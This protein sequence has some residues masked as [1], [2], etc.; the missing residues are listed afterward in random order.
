MTEL[1]C[2]FC[3][4]PDNRLF[5]RG[6]LVLGLWDQ[7]PV[8]P[9]HALVIPRRHVASWFDAT[10]EERAELMAAISITRSAIDQVHQPEGYNLGVNVG[11]AAGQTIFHVHVHL[12]PRYQG[13]VP[14]PRGGVRSAATPSALSPT[15]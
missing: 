12:I 14:A 10:D 13:D 7:F 15:R 1:P 11:H 6:R 2:P 4:P 9:G 8:S 3:S 5:H